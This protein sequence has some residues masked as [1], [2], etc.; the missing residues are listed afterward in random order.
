MLVRWQ[1]SGIVSLEALQADV[2]SL[3]KKLE[4]DGYKLIEATRMKRQ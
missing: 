2:K 4:A 1:V 3:S